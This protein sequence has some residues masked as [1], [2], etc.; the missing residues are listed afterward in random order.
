MALWDTRAIRKIDDSGWV[1]ELYKDQ[2]SLTVSPSAG[3]H[4]Y[5]AWDRAL[6]GAPSMEKEAVE[7]LRG[8]RRI[9]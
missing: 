3:R 4:G 6:G 9:E 8:V 5:A 1:D 2:P 7:S